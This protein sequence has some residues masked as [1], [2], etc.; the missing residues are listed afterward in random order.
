[1]PAV[2]SVLATHPTHVSLLVKQCG[3]APLHAPPHGTCASTLP[4]IPVSACIAASDASSPPPS[5][6]THAPALD[7]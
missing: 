3:V 6:V 2:Q 5:M 4:S 7:T 1:V